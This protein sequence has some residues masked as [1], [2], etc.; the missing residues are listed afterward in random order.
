MHLNMTFLRR[1]SLT[2]P[3]LPFWWLIDPRWGKHLF[4]SSPSLGD[5]L[6]LIIFI[7]NILPQS[8]RPR[9]KNTSESG[10][11]SVAFLSSFFILTSG[12]G[13]TTAPR[14][15]RQHANT[16]S[17]P[18]RVRAAPWSS[19]IDWAVNEAE[20]MSGDLRRDSVLINALERWEAKVQLSVGRPPPL[21]ALCAPAFN[22]I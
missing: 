12:E 18:R 19:A 2:W 7:P 6:I 8:P 11:C 5:F 14:Q 22:S 16:W 13:K 1:D 17:A 15:R 3:R 10:F 21:A 20:S 9:W 4:V